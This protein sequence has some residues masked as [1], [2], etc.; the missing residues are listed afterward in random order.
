MSDADFRT[1]DLH[2]LL[3]RLRGGE[4]DV[5]DVLYRRIS[6]R[7]ESLCRKMI[8]KQPSV[9]QF[10]ETADVMQNVALRLLRALESARPGSIRELYSLAAELARCEIMDLLRYHLAQRRCLKD[11]GRAV[12]LEA[13]IAA[14]GTDAVEL[15]RWHGFHE[16]VANLS[17]VEREVFGL[18]YYHGWSQQEIADLFQVHERTIRRQWHAACLSLKR[19]LGERMPSTSPA[20]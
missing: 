15:D 9:R 19:M 18:V 3:D 8:G 2:S 10:E 12:S 17:A 1:T 14:E 13:D 11:G 16:A 7:L 5:R 6:G 20:A 4:E